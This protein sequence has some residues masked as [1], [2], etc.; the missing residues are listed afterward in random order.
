MFVNEQDDKPID[1]CK[2]NKD[3]IN[4]V[5]D[6]AKSWWYSW[7]DSEQSKTNF[8]KDFNVSLEETTKIFEKMRKVIDLKIGRAHV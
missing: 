6:K 7:L 3:E 2:D 1:Y 4:Q 5:Y 8:S